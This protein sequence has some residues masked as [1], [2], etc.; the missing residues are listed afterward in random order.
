M[1]VKLNNK[2]YK[3][4]RYSVEIKSN[5]YLDIVPF[6]GGFKM[7][8]KDTEEY[9]KR[10]NDDMLSDWLDDPVLYGAFLDDELVGFVEGFLEE[11]N[12]RFR[13]SNICVLKEDMRNKGIG[14]ELLDSIIQEAIDSKARMVVLE[15][16]SYNYSAIKF[17]ER[18]GFEIIGF[19]RY[20]Y[21]ND[22]P[23]DHNMRVEMGK[24]LS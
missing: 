16:Q 19:D 18:N 24:A 23:S 12:N 14:K 11:W 6:D 9:T 4:K 3:G 5:K 13:I 8:W 15:T 20:A 1:V 7:E 21:S 22:G 10:L 17:Y 2:E